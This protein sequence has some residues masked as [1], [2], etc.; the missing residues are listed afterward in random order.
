MSASLLYT[1]Y[2]SEIVKMLIRAMIASTRNLE[3][4][5]YAKTKVEAP[6]I[7]SQ[8]AMNPLKFQVSIID[9]APLLLAL[10]MYIAVLG[11]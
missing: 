5:F 4:I 1:S 8:H 6:G 11:P 2:G 3:L 10:H 9:P 7:Y